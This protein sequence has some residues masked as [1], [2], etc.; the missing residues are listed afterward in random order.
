MPDMGMGDMRMARKDGMDTAWK[1]CRLASG[2]MPGMD[3]RRTHD[4]ARPDAMPRMTVR[5]DMQPGVRQSAGRHAQSA[6][7]PKLDDPGIGLRDNGRRVLTYAMLKTI[8]DPDRRASP[9]A[10][11]NC[12]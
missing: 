11:S 4:A 2:S 1:R 5:M 12:T 6:P 3:I 7:T 10:T 8:D 9:A